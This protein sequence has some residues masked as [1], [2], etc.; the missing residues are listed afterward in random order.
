MEN[1]SKSYNFHLDRTVLLFFLIAILTASSLFAYRYSTREIC[2]VVPFKTQAPEYRVGEFISFTD[3]SYGSEEWAWNFNDSTEVKTTRS[4]FH[5]YEKPG[6]YN[7]SL[8]VNG[9]CE[10]YKTVKIE[11][12]QFVLDSSKIPVFDAVKSIMVGETL[13]VKSDIEGAE[14]YE[15]HF[16]ETPGVN[17]Y[18]QE[19][20]YEFI[21]PGMKTISL[22]VNKDLK[23]RATRQIKVLEKPRE[24]IASE[25]P[26]ERVAVDNRIKVNPDLVVKEGDDDDDDDENGGV[27][28]P[29]VISQKQFGDLLLQIADK[30]AVSS[31]FQPYMCNTLNVPTIVNGKQSTFLVF[32]QRIR[33][34][35]IT[36]NDIEL[37]TDHKKGCVTNVAIDLKKSIF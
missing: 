35:T 7:V 19:A 26:R 34:K 12:K 3:Q 2:Q 29:A 31:I 16:G 20:T 15:W 27:P 1:N 24:R 5:T 33:G 11:E 8:V 25:R 36:I 10:I 6:T 37:I 4:T 9:K 17:S 22:I 32:C 23:H 18:D 28:A 13:T 21:E 14:S 30:D